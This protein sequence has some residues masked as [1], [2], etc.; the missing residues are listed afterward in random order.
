MNRC[1]QPPRSCRMPSMPCASPMMPKETQYTLAMAYV[2]V[3]TFDSIFPPMEG[4]C[5]GTIFP[6]LVKPFTGHKVE[7]CKCQD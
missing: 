3:Q 6:E 7:D 2:P 1:Y 4:L 5:K